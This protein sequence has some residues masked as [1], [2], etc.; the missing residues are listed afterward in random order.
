M[1]LNRWND[2]EAKN[3]MDEAGDDPADR[4]LALRVYTSQIIGQDSN[5]V[6][7]GGGNTSCKVKRK[8]IFGNE[9]NVLHVKGSGWDLGVIEAAGLPGVR[10]DPLLELR[11]L[12]ALSDEDMVNLQRANLL[13]STSPNPSV[14]TLLHAFLPHAYVDHT[15]ATAMLSLADLPNV[16]N[17]V[18]EIFGD[19]LVCVPFIMPGFELAKVAAQVYDAN[20]NVEGLILVNH[21][22]FAFG[23]TAKQSYNRLIEQT[24]MVEAWLEK[25]SG[26]VPKTAS[27]QSEEMSARAA[28]ILPMLRG[29][30]GDAN[31][32]FTGDRDVAMPVMDMRNGENVQE[33]FARDDLAAMSRR[34]VA[35]PDHVIRTKNYPLHLTKEILAS[36]RESVAKAVDDFIVEY[37]AYFK[38]NNAR[39]GGNKTMLLPTPNLAWIEGVG[40]VGLTANAKA[41]TV[42]SDL[43]AQNITAMINGESCGGFYP[44]DASR[45]FDMEYWSLEQAKLGKGKPPTMQGRV[46]MVTGGGGSIGLATAHEFATLGADVFLVDQE[47]EAL[48]NALASLGG[49]HSGIALDITETN[50][51]NLAMEACIQEFGGID[52]LVSNAGAAWTGEMA[53]LDDETLR[54]SFEL[55]F[56]AHQNFSKAAA[57]I[58]AIQGRG[59]QILINVSKQAVNPGKGFG[60][61]GIPKAATFFLLRQLALELGPHGVRVNGIN[62]DRIR[63]GLLDQSFVTERAAARGIDEEMYMAGNLLRREVEA[64]HVGKAFVALAQSE[65]TTAH[66][67]TVDG[68]NIEAALR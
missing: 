55:N 29:I 62:A 19:S 51:A 58:F 26:S 44:V 50:S 41:A 5:L 64:A 2:N 13:D 56:F 46:V 25:T 63:S 27:G 47:S 30:I 37:T 66:V 1:V 9:M 7:H 4:E 21:G 61:Y 28:D 22:H 15:H 42:A 59:G 67:M 36:G 6:L 38:A 54:K 57:N 48:Q 11:Q 65:R 24:N 3:F 49:N 68:G 52:I 31:A 33:F 23:D 32:K 10:L 39:S 8:D 35:T 18:A 12:D 40:V 53:E 60:A 16:Q 20:P 45:L 14:E 43:A 34:G 17:V